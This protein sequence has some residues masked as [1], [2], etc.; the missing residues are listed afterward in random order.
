[1]SVKVP[2]VGQIEQFK[3]L[4]ECKQMTYNKLNSYC[5]IRIFEAL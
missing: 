1:M 2:P 3:H 4:I 5:Y